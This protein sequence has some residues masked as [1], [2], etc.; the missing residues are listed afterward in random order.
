M[1]LTVV[2]CTCS[3]HSYSRKRSDQNSYLSTEPAT[4]WIDNMSSKI[5]HFSFNL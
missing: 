2:A 3:D 5:L 1:K 4:I